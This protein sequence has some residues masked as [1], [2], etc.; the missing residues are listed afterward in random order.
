MVA[1]RHGQLVLGGIRPL[2]VL[3]GL[4][5]AACFGSGDFL[6]GLASRR[7]KTLAVLGVAQVAAVVLA[8]V[9]TLATGGPA[10]AHDIEFGVVAGL[11]NV[12]AIGCLYRG[13]ALGQMGQVAP[14]A[15]VIGAVVPVAWGV[16]R[17]ESLSLPEIIGIVFAVIAGALLSSE[18]GARNGPLLVPAVLLAAAAGVGFGVSLILFSAASHHGGMWPALS[19]RL[20]AC[21]VVWILLLVRRERHELAQ[22]PKTEAAAAGVLDVGA[23]MILLVT[24][25][26]HLTAVIA[27]VASLAPAFTAGHA[28]WYLHERT[29]RLQLVG[30]VLALIGLA[31]IAID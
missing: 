11:L 15:A 20:A 3:L 12:A 16:L 4:L 27:P 19:A 14:V 31:L 13:L 9:V 6:G 25:K 7:A 1:A 22:V 18:P 28:W 29:S 23:T 17:G 30:L 10:Y 5:V 8:L 24:L 2:G 21:A 26:S